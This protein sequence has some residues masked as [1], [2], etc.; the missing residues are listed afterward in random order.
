MHG[1]NYNPYDMEAFKKASNLAGALTTLLRNAG[2][3]LQTVAYG[4]EAYKNWAEQVSTVMEYI[5]IDTTRTFTVNDMKYSK[6]ENGYWE[7]EANSEAKAAYEQMNANNRTYEFA[8]EKTRKQITYISNYYL[9]S[10]PESIKTAWQNTLE[11]TGINPFAKGFVSTLTQLST[12]QD[13]LTGGDYNLFGETTES[14]LKA[15]QKILERI[16]K[17][18]EGN[19]EKTATFREQEKEFYS[20]LAAKIEQL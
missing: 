9:E 14:C 8:D 3:T 7:S 1:K 16:E 20:V 13:F 4:Q 6:N 17:P 10:V 2:G 18:L 19:T 12:E 15:I 5:G 11:E